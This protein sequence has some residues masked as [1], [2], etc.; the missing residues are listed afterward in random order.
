MRSSPRLTGALLSGPVAAQGRVSVPLR[1]VI[2]R[3][4]LRDTWRLEGEGGGQRGGTLT[5]ELAWVG[6]LAM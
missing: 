4:R 6:A 1:A 2:E 3:R 5:M